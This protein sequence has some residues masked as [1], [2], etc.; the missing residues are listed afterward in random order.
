MDA[1]AE[2]L[3]DRT[4][5]PQQLSDGSTRA[6][7]REDLVL[8]HLARVIASPLAVVRARAAT[9]LG[10]VDD[11]GSEDLLARLLGDRDPTVRVPAADA[12]A[13]RA[14]HVPTA[15]LTAL[16]RPRCAVAGASLVIACAVG[17][18]SRKRPEAFQ[19]LL[20]VAKAGEP[21][22]QARAVVW[23]GAL[24]DHRA[25]EHLLPLFEP[26]PEATE[27]ERAL[28]P[29]AAEALGRM[30]PALEAQAQGRGDALDEA[31]DIRGRVE[32]LALAGSGPARCA[33]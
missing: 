28:Q 15:T 26:S 1:L 11:R 17:L 2:I 25:L 16:G 22:E 4:K 5:K 12:L 3:R 9:M 14:E 23:L 10:D 33:R 7:Y 30:L 8:A 32:R 13:L 19:P 6:R 24:G 18:A 27:A 31:N 21:A 20:L 29:A